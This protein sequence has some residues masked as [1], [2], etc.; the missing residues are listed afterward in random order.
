MLIKGLHI[1]HQLPH[2]L[3]M[4]LTFQTQPTSLPRWRDSHIQCS[5][6]PSLPSRHHNNEHFYKVHAYYLKCTRPNLIL[7]ALLKEHRPQI[8]SN[9]SQSITEPK[10]ASIQLPVINSLM[11][12][13][14]E[15]LT[16]EKTMDMPTPTPIHRR[17]EPLHESKFMEGLRQTCWELKNITETNQAQFM[18]FTF[19]VEVVEMV[20]VLPQ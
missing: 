1:T 18:K 2:H 10:N 9:I 19:V 8:K 15:E 4:L 6:H 3:C 13:N 20:E 12:H 11:K 7:P 16:Q 5:V 14:C 17:G